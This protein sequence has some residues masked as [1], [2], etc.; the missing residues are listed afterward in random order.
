[1]PTYNFFNTITEEYFSFSLKMSERE[2][3]LKEN[4][5][6]N[7]VPSNPLI[8]SGRG[9]GKPDEGFRDILRDIKKKHSKGFTR[10]TVNT[11]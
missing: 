5:F 1:V 7:Q 4:P 9:L 2:K 11:F 8:H 10:S 6:I 3:Y